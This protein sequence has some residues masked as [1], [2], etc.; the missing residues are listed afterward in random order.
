MS[1]SFLCL[2][3]IVVFTCFF[4]LLSGCNVIGRNASVK[5]QRKK[6]LA[7]KKVEK[8]AYK[9]MQK[10]HLERQSD[11]TKK[12]MKQLKKRNK[13]LNKSLRKKRY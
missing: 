11:E 6:E 4:L 12:S 3:S 10:A 5:E 2:R 9:T 13:K 7:V 8:K 1:K